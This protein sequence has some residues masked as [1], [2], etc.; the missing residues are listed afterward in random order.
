VTLSTAVHDVAAVPI[1]VR[2]SAGTRPAATTPK[3]TFRRE[4]FIANTHDYIL[5]FSSGRVYWLKVYESQGSRRLRGQP[6]VN[7]VR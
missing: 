4:V 5:C 1:I 2:R 3:E 7:L 6:I